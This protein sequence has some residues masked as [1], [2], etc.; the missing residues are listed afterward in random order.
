MLIL[1]LEVENSFPALEISWN[2]TLSSTAAAHQLPKVTNCRI[3][4]PVW[5]KRSTPTV[6]DSDSK[7]RPLAALNAAQISTWVVR[8]V[9]QF[10]IWFKKKPLTE[11][12]GFSILVGRVGL[13]PTTKGFWFA[14][15]SSLP[16]LCLH[17]M[18][19]AL[20]WA[21]S[22]L[23]T[24]PEIQGLARHWH[25][26]RLSFHRIWRHSHERFP[27][28]VHNFHES[29]ALTNWANAP[30]KTSNSRQP[31]P[32]KSLLKFSAKCGSGVKA[33]FQHCGALTCWF[34]WGF[35]DNLSS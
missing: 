33:N 11:I 22:S 12:S 21:P 32:T 24:F 13:E 25:I 3:F 18:H 34:H 27:L 28:S 1:R 4:S 17:R 35:L 7:A 20:R 10:R 14:W 9:A 31:Q 6:T 26:S 5:W 15:L 30:L 29:S 8:K 16:G 19:V 2:Q 23:Y